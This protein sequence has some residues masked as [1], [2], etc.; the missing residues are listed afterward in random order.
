MPGA[1]PYGVLNPKLQGYVHVYIDTA[2]HGADPGFR[3]VILLSSAVK[4]AITVSFHT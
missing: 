2:D 3:K 1:L 4:L